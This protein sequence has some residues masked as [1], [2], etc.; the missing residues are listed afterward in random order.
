MSPSVVSPLKTQKILLKMD[1][2]LR[3]LF[4]SKTRRNVEAPG[5]QIEAAPR[6]Q[7][8]LFHA[9]RITNSVWMQAGD[10]VYE[11]DRRN[12][13]KH[14]NRHPLV[15]NAHPSP[16][17][18]GVFGFRSISRVDQIVHAAGVVPAA[19]A[20]VA[21]IVYCQ[22]RDIKDTSDPFFV[23]FLC[24]PMHILNINACAQHVVFQVFKNGQII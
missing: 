10:K 15:K 18:A 5:K 8:L 2:P 19:A 20:I 6:K 4:Q 16:W 23:Y 12:F 21:R 14:L 24:I 13:K 22:F 9:L 1:T 17:I 3:F 7:L 11:F